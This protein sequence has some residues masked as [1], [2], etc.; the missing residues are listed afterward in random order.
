MALIKRHYTD[1]ETLITAQNLNDIQD[2]VLELEAGL[3][4]MDN[5][6]SGEAVK[7]S[8]A[9]S[10]GLIGLKIYGK[11]TQ[12]GTPTLDTPIGMV[13]AAEDSIS[14]HV[15]G[16]NLF[17]G[18]EVGGIASGDGSDSTG[19][20]KR[21]TGYL[22][23]FTSGQRIAIS[24][25]PGT[26]YS[27]AVFYDA[28]KVFISRSA[29]GN[30]SER[31][32]DAP[33]S[34]KYFRVTVYESS[35]AS[36]V[37]AEADAMAPLTQI[38]AGGA[39]T[40][41]ERAKP[42]QTAVISSLNGLYG[43]PVSSGGNYTDA[44]EQQWI[45]DE[46]DFRRGVYIKRVGQIVYD[47]S[48]S[49]FF[50]NTDSYFYRTIPDRKPA[51]N[52][53]CDKLAHTALNNTGSPGWWADNSGNRYF[54]V[55]GI[56]SAGLATTIEEFQAFL[57][58]NPLTVRYILETPVETP[59]TEENIT[60]YTALHTYRDNTT[61]SNSGHAYMDLEYTMDAKKYID[62]LAF[63]GGAVA[64]VLSS[65]TLLASAWAGSDSLYS[66]VVTIDGVTEYSK[67]DL[68]PS[69]EQL[70]IFHNK[71]VAFVTENENGVVT[72]YA[73]GDKPTNDYTMQVSITEVIA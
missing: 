7:T 54:A 33:T 10:R 50:G 67:V 22:P 70:A 35:S 20:T 47:G 44:N 43:I 2:A 69:V 45:C 58:E 56:V 30:Y 66:Q 18:W 64:S 6:Q 28:E 71:D 37:I 31:F 48:E 13:S 17:T 68:L 34:A 36:G 21:R 39:Y 15:C 65:V 1:E 72:V 27:M 53:L 73:I 3:F 42:I 51:S 60:A 52:I 24:G 61:I 38:E 11:T 23:V 12:D 8:D 25:I 57:T 49:W 4:A 5:E 29:A 55:T 46:I 63:S 26:L 41:Y 14:V 62:R 59:L 32:F 40:E 16:K 19:D 9:A